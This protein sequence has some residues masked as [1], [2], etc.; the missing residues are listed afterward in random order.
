V[1]SDGVNRTPALCY[2]LNP[3][4]R[5]DQ[6]ST[7]LRDAKVAHQTAILKKYGLD[8]DRVVVYPRENG[9]SKQYVP[10]CA[11]IVHDFMKFYK[12]EMRVAHL[13][14]RDGGSSFVES[15]KS[16]FDSYG[17]K[18]VVYPSECH[19]YISPNDNP[20]HGVVKAIVRG[21]CEDLSD[22]VDTSLRLLH[23]LDNIKPDT[24]KG[25]WERNFLAGDYKGMHRRAAELISGTPN[26]LLAYHRECFKLYIAFVNGDDLQPI[27]A[28]SPLEDDLDGAYWQSPE[29]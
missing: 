21:K 6:P 3:A 10:E 7:P 22:D 23:E 25:W 5:T 4:F 8:G 12:R 27:S 20:A 24:I 26:K 1:W 14:F 13:A 17:L 28:S 15:G 16:V 18:H 29:E 19:Q 9:N 2:T 11:W